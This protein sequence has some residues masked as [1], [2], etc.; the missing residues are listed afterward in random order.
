MASFYPD[1]PHFSLPTA[2]AYHRL[3]HSFFLRPVSPDEVRMTILSLKN[4]G[5]GLENFYSS[6]IKLIAHLISNAL[7]HIINI[8]LKTGVF[9]SCLK[10]AKIIPVFK[11]GSKTSLLN[12]RPIAILSFFTKL[13]EK[14]FASH[15]TCSFSKFSI[16]SSNQFGFRPGYSTELALVT[17]TDHLKTA[18]DEGKFAG[19][20]FIDFSKAFDFL[21]H[22]YFLLNEM[23]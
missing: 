6:L 20:L 18:I 15:L 12:Y 4:T 21:N 2:N 8:V 14:L 22:A 11:K 7:S 3:P 10:I 17:I 23:R 9:P 19:S 16:L 1:Q 5:A 13:I